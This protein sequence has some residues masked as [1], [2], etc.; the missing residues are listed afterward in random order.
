M[1]ASSPGLPLI[2]YNYFKSFPP[3]GRIKAW[4]RGYA[5]ATQG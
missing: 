1:L 4:G 2:I 5:Y 3:Q